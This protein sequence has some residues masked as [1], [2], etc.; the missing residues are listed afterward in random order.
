MADL[1]RDFVFTRN[2]TTVAATDTAITVEDVS[3][4]PSNT[5][6][7]KGDFYIAFESSLSYP[8]TFEIMKLTN[9]NAATKTL[10]VIRAQ[11][12]TTAQAHAIVTY[13]KGTLTSDMLRRARWAFSGTL[14][15]AP[16]ADVFGVGDRFYHTSENRFYAFTG[17]AAYLVDTFTR[18][19]TALTMG[20]TETQ[21][22]TAA[23]L[24]YPPGMATSYTVPYIAPWFTLTT[25]VFG[26]NASGQ[27]YLASGGAAGSCSVVNVGSTN[28][29]MSFDVF[30]ST[31]T[32]SDYGLFLRADTTGQYGYYVQFLNTSVR[33]FRVNNGVFGDSGL[34]GSYT[35]NAMHT[36]RVVANGNSIQIFR[37]GTL[38]INFVES[39]AAFMTPSTVIGA[40]VGF[41][42]GNAAAVADAAIVWDNFSCTTPGNT[43]LNTPTAQ[44]WAPTS[45]L[46][47][48][49]AT[50][51]VAKQLQSVEA[52]LSAVVSQ[53]D[54]AVAA[55]Q[56]TEA[57]I[58]KHDVDNPVIVNQM[59]DLLTVVQTLETRSQDDD[60]FFPVLANQMD[61]LLQA[62]QLYNN[63]PNVRTTS[64]DTALADGDIMFANATGQAGRALLTPPQFD[65]IATSA[66]ANSTLNLTLAQPGVIVSVTSEWATSGSIMKLD[67]NAMT[68]VSYHTNNTDVR[69]FASNSTAGAHSVVTSG[70]TTNEPINVAL[71]LS[72][73]TMVG[74][75][76]GGGAFGGTT[77]G[78]FT[79]S[80][81]PNSTIVLFGVVN[82]SPGPNT[83]TNTGTALTW[84]QRA[85]FSSPSTNAIT[86]WT[87]YNLANSGT[88]TI[89]VSGVNSWLTVDAIAFAMDPALA[90]SGGNVYT[91]LS[92]PTPVRGGH[93]IVY[94]NDPVIANTVRFTGIVNGET[95]W[96][97][98]GRGD[99]ANLYSDGTTWYDIAAKTT[100]APIT[101]NYTMTTCDGLVL[102]NGTLTVT[103]PLLTN[104]LGNRYSVKNI[105]TGTVTVVPN[106]SSA[107]A[108]ID[109]AASSV[110]STRY[111]KV[112]FFGD[113][114][115]WWTA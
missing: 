109:G 41:R 63:P 102:A 107:G 30:A 7:A 60:L 78:S 110:I 29:D 100:I 38:V 111:A 19:A 73:A 32:T 96:F 34:L 97:L 11:A 106:P 86:V 39:V 17:N 26:I 37:D 114:T 13:I 105:G 43:A 50:N 31:T 87:A 72:G 103:L 23:Q 61:D 51:F 52:N 18:A 85:A 113:G 108:T 6:L 76:E 33:L 70:Q 45:D 14:A 35:N 47:G 82:S 88:I 84:T 77:S 4:F 104:G 62:V 80:V 94:N 8:P 1:Y 67:T 3:L 90:G 36:W 21:I 48:Y 92:L 20:L 91:A 89:N 46:P 69:A 71:A 10:T 27:A 83:I 16:D 57:T 64:T 25:G 22:L 40:H 59:D 115:N 28:F 112:D 79:M 66:S 101:S 24:G 99:I 5:M 95:N 44:G 53:L 54:D 74:Y 9:V 98:Q 49:G 56:A 93:V 55:D 81:V 65:V 58:A 15:P 12:G 75:T 68:Q 42:Y 2:T